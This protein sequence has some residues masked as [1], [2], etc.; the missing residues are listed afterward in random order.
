MSTIK[1]YKN[2]SWDDI[3]FDNLNKDYGAY[4]LRKLVNKNTLRGFL[5]SMAGFIALILV[6]RLGVFSRAN[7]KE[8]VVDLEMTDVV[9]E[10]VPPPVEAAPP[11]PPPPPPPPQRP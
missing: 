6:L 5:Y 4:V 8:K 1:D 2:A 7:K 11:P 10:D 3:V 9:M